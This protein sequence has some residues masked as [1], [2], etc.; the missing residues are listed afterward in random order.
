MREKEAIERRISY[1]R[2]GAQNKDIL[3]KISGYMDDATTPKTISKDEAD[4]WKTSYDRAFQDTI[5]LNNS[6]KSLPLHQRVTGDIKEDQIFELFLED[7][8]NLGDRQ[9]ALPTFFS[10]NRGDF[11]KKMSLHAQCLA[12]PRK[13]CTLVGK[14]RKATSDNF[15]FVV[16]RII[17]RKIKKVKR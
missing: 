11:K 12:R 1:V 16:R 5:A 7:N 17:V 6:D 4:A 2:H 3:K 8:G 14:I 9:F 15:A 10:T 13:E